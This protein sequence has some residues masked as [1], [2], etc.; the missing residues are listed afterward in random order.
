LITVKWKAFFDTRSTAADVFPETAW[1]RAAARA[2]SREQDRRTRQQDRDQLGLAIEDDQLVRYGTTRR[3]RVDPLRTVAR[4]P[5][6]E[7]VWAA[8]DAT[9]TIN[10]VGGLAVG[11]VGVLARRDERELYLMITLR[12]EVWSVPLRPLRGVRAR[13][14]AARLLT[15]RL[16]RDL[17]DE[18]Q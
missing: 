13:D 12:R 16:S 17:P 11:P 2:Q 6:D 15:A 5:L 4:V 7:V 9:G 1:G 8:V 14:F 3:G 10:T 18:Q